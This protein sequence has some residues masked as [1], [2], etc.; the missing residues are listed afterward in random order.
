M[1]QSFNVSKT[2]GDY[3]LF[4]SSNPFNDFFT[5]NMLITMHHSFLDCN[6]H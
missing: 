3:F 5:Q 1:F 4:G 2:L 6:Q